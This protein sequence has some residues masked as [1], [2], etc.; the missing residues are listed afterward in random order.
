MVDFKNIVGEAELHGW[1]D[2]GS[3]QIAFCRGYVGFIS[4]NNGGDNMAEILQTCLPAGKYCDVISGIA[5]ENGECSGKTVNVSVYGEA[6]IEIGGDDDY[7]V[8]VIH[9][10]NRSMLYK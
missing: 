8:M 10:G 1:W 6:L 5:S 7:G 2:N 9:I 4:F 3:N